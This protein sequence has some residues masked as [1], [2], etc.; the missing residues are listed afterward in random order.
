MTNNAFIRSDSGDAE[1]A[2]LLKIAAPGAL[3]AVG[4][5]RPGNEVLLRPLRDVRLRCGKEE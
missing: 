5:L 3:Y 1:V 2:A 4:F